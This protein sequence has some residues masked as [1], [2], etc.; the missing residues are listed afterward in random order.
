[1]YRLLVRIDRACSLTR[2]KADMENVFC[3]AGVV[4]VAAAAAQHHLDPRPERRLQA[5]AGASVCGRKQISNR[6]AR[7][8]RH[9]GW[10]LGR[11]GIQ[12][13]YCPGMR[14]AC[15]PYKALEHTCWRL[16]RH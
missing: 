12:Q 13:H 3:A 11:D 1:M 8:R 4:L 16:V 2:V 10:E 9:A 5:P 7:G 6:L 15:G 14:H